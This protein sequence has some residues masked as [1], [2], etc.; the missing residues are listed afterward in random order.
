MLKNPLSTLQLIS[1]RWWNASAYYAIA[2][3]KILQQNGMPVYVGGSANT[4]SIQEAKKENLPV[5]QLNFESF[6]PWYFLKNL[7]NY[8]NFISAKKIDIINAHRPEDHF[9]SALIKKKYTGLPLI[10]TVGDVR[11]PKNN[12]FNKNLHLNHTDFFI[13]S[14]RA[15]K[16]RYQNVWPVLD[17]KSTVVYAGVDTDLFSPPANV[18]MSRNKMNLPADAV[19]FGMVGRFSPVKDHS[20]FLKAAARI[21]EK[22]RNVR[23]IISGEEVEITRHLLEEKASQLGILNQVLILEKYQDVREVMNLIDIGVVCSLDSEAISRVTAEFMSMGKPVIVTDINVLPE[24]VTSGRDG[25]VVPAQ[26]PERLSQAMEIFVENYELRMKMGKQARKTAM[27]RFSYS[28]F[29]DD[30]INKY[31][32]VLKMCSRR[33]PIEGKQK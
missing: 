18:E 15:N 27:E 31:Q 12:R 2:L 26:S 5:L 3:S 13:F 6:Y 32:D 28:R 29:Y 19:A 22:K 33:I 10:R 16:I 20:S 25:F 17:Q 8:R 4:P 30:T 9:Y 21:I 24:M 11:P 23:F 1:V 7:R 14:C